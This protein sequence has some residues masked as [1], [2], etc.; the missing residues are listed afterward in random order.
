MKKEENELP[1]LITFYETKYNR[2]RQDAEIWKTKL[3]HVI[4]IWNNLGSFEPLTEPEFLSFFEIQP[5]KPNEEQI[6]EILYNKV[7]AGRSIEL[8]GLKLNR[9]AIDITLPNIDELI[10]TIKDLPRGILPFQFN[11]ITLKK[12]KIE[13]N[14]K[15]FESIKKNQCSLFAENDA[16]LKRFNLLKPVIEGLN[17]L[18]ISENLDPIDKNKIFAY[19]SIVSVYDTQFIPSEHFIKFGDLSTAYFAY[20]AKGKAEN[21]KI[22]PGSKEGAIM[23]SLEKS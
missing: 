17:K 4:D 18:F 8:N 22:D 1:V 16:E 9:S 13:L 2:I 14:E 21:V 20:E 23:A 19:G 12:G 7:L 6:N 3:N 10:E 11:W 5:D 15:T